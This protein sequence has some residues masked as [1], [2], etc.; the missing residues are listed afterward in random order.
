MEEV[1]PA[2]EGDIGGPA[3]GT[4][5]SQT[6]VGCTKVGFLLETESHPGKADTDA[7]NPT[8]LDSGYRTNLYSER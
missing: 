1:V 2:V 3:I 6:A 4:V 7:D 5:L 8:L